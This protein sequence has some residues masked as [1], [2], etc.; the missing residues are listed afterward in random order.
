MGRKEGNPKHNL[1]YSAEYRIWGNMLSRCHN[2]NAPNYKNY[3]GRGITCDP[4]WRSFTEFYA[5]LGPRP[6]SK[7][8]LDRVNNDGNYNKQNCRWATK[9]E[10]MLNRRL[11][12]NN[13]SGLSHVHYEASQNRW[14]ARCYIDGKRTILYSGPDLFEAACARKSWENTHG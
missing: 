3:G 5:D 10:Q 2:A 9:Q 11:F 12:H 8:Q 6:S 14:R 13:N 1:C 4:R 7:H